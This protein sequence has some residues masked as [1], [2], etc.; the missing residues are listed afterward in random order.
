MSPGALRTPGVQERSGVIH[1]GNFLLDE[2]EL[3]NR[4][5]RGDVE[6]FGNLV[7]CYAADIFRLALSLGYRRGE[8]EDLMQDTFLAAF[9]SIQRYEQRSTFKTWLL[10]ILFRQSSRMRRYRGLRK[11]EALDDPALQ[12]AHRGAIARN[13]VNHESRLDAHTMLD[14]LSSEHRTVLVLRELQGMS[15]DE[16][17]QTLDIPRGTVESRLFRARAILRDRFVDYGNRPADP[18]VRPATEPVESRHE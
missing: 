2:T 5:A 11:T 17:A 13:S 18:P 12:H 16:I 14:T 3:V 6:A 8:A 10:A 4:A 9:E 7:D 15:Y 1:R